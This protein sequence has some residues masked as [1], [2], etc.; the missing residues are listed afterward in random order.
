MDLTLYQKNYIIFGSLFFIIIY[1]V[2]LIYI[3]GSPSLIWDIGFT[4]LSFL[5]IVSISMIVSNL[6]LDF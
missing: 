4:G 2:Y 6:S 5:L 3:K 1:S